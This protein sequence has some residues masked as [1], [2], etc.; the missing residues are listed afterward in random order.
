[1]RARGG[2]LDVEIETFQSNVE[3]EIIE[4]LQQRA[5]EA[6]G[7]MTEGKSTEDAAKA[8]TKTVARAIKALGCPTRLTEVGVTEADLHPIA[9]ATFDELRPGMNPRRVHDPDEILEILKAAL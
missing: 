6:A 1:M 2:E 7:V 5:G 3:G 9:Q 8:A 4:F